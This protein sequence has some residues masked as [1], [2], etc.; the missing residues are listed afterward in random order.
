M[1]NF[2]LWPLRPSE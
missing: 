2:L 1:T